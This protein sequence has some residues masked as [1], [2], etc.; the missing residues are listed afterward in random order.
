MSTTNFKYDLSGCPV[1]TPSVPVG[2]TAIGRYMPERILSNNDFV[3]I[4]LSEEEKGFF[5]T[6]PNFA[7]NKR[8][9]AD[10]DLPMDM[11]VKA[12]KDAIDRYSVDPLSIDLV[13]FTSSSKDMARLAPPASNYVQTA[14]GAH[15]ANS[16]NVDCG[17][18][19][20]L[21]TV[22][23]ASAF[24]AGDFYK[25]VMVVT[26]ETVIN[27]MDTNNSK[28][29]LMGDGAGAFVMEKVDEGYGML[30]CHLMAKE[31]PDA[32]GIK[33]MEGKGELTS[34]KSEIKPYLYVTPE[35][36]GRDIP[37]LQEYI[38]HSVKKCLDAVAKDTTDV[39]CYVL[40]Q[41]F[42]ALSHVW[43][44]KLKVDYSRFHDTIADYACLKCASIPVT[45]FDA[46]EK[47]KIKKGDLVALGDQG[48]NWSISSALFRWC[49]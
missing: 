22:A 39:D 21:P 31:C 36:F 27:H 38:P 10:G 33:L 4:K 28:A 18:N 2:I 40:G 12:A 43:A 24:I 13:L 49:I 7:N 45:L 29:L 23:T 37:A 15:N 42:M 11:A 3:N 46:V 48:A 32:A 5:H 9:F 14:I 6:D 17:F 20:W 1:V 8:R 16:F 30:A 47:G 26:G 25:K 35:S 41:Q 34:N 44:D 19:G